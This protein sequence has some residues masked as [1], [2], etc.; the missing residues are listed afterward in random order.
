MKNQNIQALRGLS[1]L[2]VVIIHTL[3]Q[4]PLR[5]IVRPF[6]VYAVALFIFLS[7]YLTKTDID[8]K[9]SFMKKRIVKVLIPYLVW[10]LIYLYT[11]DFSDFVFKLLTGSVC[12]AFY[13]IFVYIQF[14]ILTPLIV[15]LA[16]SKYSWVGWLITPLST[17]VCRYV[18]KYYGLTF[19]DKNFKYFFFAWFIYY[20]MGIF[21]GNKMISLKREKRTYIVLYII[22]LF[23]TFA[24]SL[25]FKSLGNEDLTFTQLRLSVIFSNVCF[26]TLCHIFILNGREYKNRIYKTFVYLGNCSSGIYF[27][28]L[29]I[30]Y[31]IFGRIPVLN[32]F[33]LNTIIVVAVSALCVSA[34]K[35]ILGKYSYVLGL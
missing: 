23:A 3:Y 19:L 11:Q 10:S 5:I 33:P 25:L 35:K 13:Y 18:F 8:D 14:V 24:E 29:L 26:L 2:A 6:V 12:V 7:G 16:K 22:S 32:V 1:I 9:L 15:R 28:H 31:V 17:F 34:G 4:D 30:R 21:M 20:Y 27:S